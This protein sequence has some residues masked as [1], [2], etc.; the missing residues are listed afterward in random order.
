MLLPPNVDNLLLAG[1]CASMTHE[2][3]SAAPAS[4][5]CFVMA[6]ASGTAA[7]L[8]QASPRFADINVSALQTSL[9]NDGVYL[10]HDAT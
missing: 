7:A 3:Q 5:A 10:D 1:R 2:G 6:Q 4:G 8:L 9:I